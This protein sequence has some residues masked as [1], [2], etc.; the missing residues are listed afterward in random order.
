MWPVRNP[1]SIVPSMEAL[2]GAKKKDPAKC[3]FCVGHD[4]PTPPEMLAY[5][6]VG[7]A[8]GPGW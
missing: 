2:A 8:D 4:Q 5:R 3:P 7:R 1:K 6:K